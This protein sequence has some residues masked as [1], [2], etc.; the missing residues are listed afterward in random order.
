MAKSSFKTLTFALSTLLMFCLTLQGCSQ[1]VPLAGDF[2][3]PKGSSLYFQTQMSSTS[4]H[5]GV[6]FSLSD[7]PVTKKDRDFSDFLSV[8]LFDDKGQVFRPEKVWDVNGGRRDIVATFNSIPRGTQIKQV[9]VLA[10]Q[11][12]QGDKIRW[13]SG[14]LK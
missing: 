3:I 6:Y 4:T 11:E 12:L 14:N 9:R 10:F 5:S 13:W 2:Q 8:E 7:I 1:E